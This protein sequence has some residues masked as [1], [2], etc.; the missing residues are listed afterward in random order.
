MRKHFGQVF[1]LTMM[2]LLVAAGTGMAQWNGEIEAWGFNGA[3]QCNVPSPNSGFVAVAG[4]YGHSLGLKEDGS[5]VAWGNNYDGQCDVPSP[6]SGFE[7]ITGGYF[8]SL[9]LKADGSIMAWGDNFHGQCDAPSPNEGFVSVAGGEGFSLGLKEDG[10][11]VAWGDNEFGQCSVPSPNSGFV[12][13]AGGGYHSL[14]LKED[15]SIVAWGLNQSGQCDVPSPNSGFVAVAGGLEHSLGLKED[16]SIVVWGESL[17]V[18]PPNTG[19]VA[20][21]AGRGWHNLGLREIGTGVED[22]ELTGD[23]IQIQSVAPNPF[24][25]ITT[26][27]FQ[28]PGLSTLTLQVYDTAGRLVR[29]Q[30]LGDSQAGQNS[31]TWDGKDSQGAELGTGVYFIRLMIAEQQASAKV[32]LVR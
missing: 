3:G 4:G 8:H 16:G 17:G 31:V 29:N 14:G 6:N 12:A 7:A 23:F 18:P 22:L 25:T 15:G 1:L 24:S 11:I 28:S 20:V 30:F 21:S 32:I 10:S 27:L 5:I 9:G 2:V 19:F 13:V 26:V